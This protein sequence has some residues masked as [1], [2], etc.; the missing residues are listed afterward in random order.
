MR[1]SMNTQ[2]LVG[3]VAGVALG[4]GLGALPLDA[5]LSTPDMCALHCN[6]Q[7]ELET[8]ERCSPLENFWCGGSPAQPQEQALVG[9]WDD[10]VEVRQPAT[11]RVESSNESEHDDFLMDHDE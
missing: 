3:A 10:C 1:M 2:I 5:A 7:V 11:Q 9:E 8:Y 4:V 6:A